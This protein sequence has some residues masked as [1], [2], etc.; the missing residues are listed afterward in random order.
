MKKWGLL[1]IPVFMLWMVI[2]I[3]PPCSGEEDLFEKGRAGDISFLSGGVGKQEREILKEIGGK[4][5]LKLIFSNK[6]GEYLSDVIVKVLDQN[7]KTILTTV[8][9]GPWVFI[10]LPSGT[11]HLMASFKGNEKKISKVHIKK[12]TQEVISIQW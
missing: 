11:Y 5:P 6:K 8:S 12:G 2:F 10:N 1:S 4:Y 3:L 7:D 9:N